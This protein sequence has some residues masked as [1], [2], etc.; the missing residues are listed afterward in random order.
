[1]FLSVWDMILIHNKR[2][3]DSVPKKE[4]KIEK[5]EEEKRRRKRKRSKKGTSG[6]LC[7]KSP[8]LSGAFS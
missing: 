2:K 6:S 3:Q 1:M 7:F 8:S 5:K 4:A